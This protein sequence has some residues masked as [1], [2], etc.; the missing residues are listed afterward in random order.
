MHVMLKEQ[1][2]YSQ[3]QETGEYDTLKYEGLLCVW[4]GGG[5]MKEKEILLLVNP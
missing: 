2:K 3:R 5:E 4:R 1:R